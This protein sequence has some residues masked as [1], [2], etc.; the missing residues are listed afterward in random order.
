MSLYLVTVYIHILATV[1]WAGYALFWT[2]MAS[3]L[4]HRFAATESTHYLQ[5]VHR[6]TWPPQGIPTPFRL[7]F[8]ALGWAVLIVLLCTGALIVQQQGVT[9]S[10]LLTGAASPY[11]L[12]KLGVVTIACICQLF[13]SFRPRIPLIHVNLGLALGIVALSVLLVR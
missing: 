1:F 6:A 10:Q 7:T 9:L 4:T 12:V 5:L 2:I 13:L 8:P 11:L 3:T